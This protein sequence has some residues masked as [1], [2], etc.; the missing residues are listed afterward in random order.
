MFSWRTLYQL[1]QEKLGLT[2]G[3]KVNHVMIY[4]YGKEMK[5][6]ARQAYEAYTGN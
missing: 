3:Q 1:W 2:G 4:G 6:I 5:E